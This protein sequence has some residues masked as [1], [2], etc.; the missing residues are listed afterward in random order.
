[1]KDEIARYLGFRSYNI[2]FGSTSAHITGNSWFV[3]LKGS[4]IGYADDYNSKLS[5]KNFKATVQILVSSG[6]ICYVSTERVV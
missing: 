6:E 2:S 3:T 1:M 4:V 5:S